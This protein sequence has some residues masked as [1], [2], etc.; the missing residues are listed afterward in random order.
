MKNKMMLSLLA[1]GIFLSSLT[2]AGGNKSKKGDGGDV[3]SEKS[4]L[5]NIGIGVPW[6]GYVPGSGYFATPAISGS[7]EVGVHKWVSV[8]GFLEFDAAGWSIDNYSYHYPNLYKGN[9]SN[10]HFATGVKGSFHFSAIG[11]EKG[12]VE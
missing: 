8:G 12:A 9:Y 1:G 3:F 7:L 10:V 6:L 4:L 2:F 11:N 5:L